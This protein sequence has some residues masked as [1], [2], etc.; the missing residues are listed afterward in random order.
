MSWINPQSPVKSTKKV[1]KSGLDWVIGWIWVL[2][3][4]ISLK[5]QVSGKPRLKPKKLIVPLI[6]N[7]L[8]QF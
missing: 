7:L 8:L 3:L 1:R 4:K 5:N 6:Q 2:K